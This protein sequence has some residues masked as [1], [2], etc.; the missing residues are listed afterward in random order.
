MGNNNDKTQPIKKDNSYSSITGRPNI[1]VISKR[2]QEV[3]KRE[4]K[5]FYTTAGTIV[6]LFI[7]V[8]AVLI[9]FF[10]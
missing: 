6:T 2:N 5:T 10:S 9:Y 7:V 4:K 3:E 8:V 1:D